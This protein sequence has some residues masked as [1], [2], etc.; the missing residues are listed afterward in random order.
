MHELARDLAE[1]SG[2][3]LKSNAEGLLDPEMVAA[4]SPWSGQNPSFGVLG[5]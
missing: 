1:I 3:E 4:T 5:I 2:M